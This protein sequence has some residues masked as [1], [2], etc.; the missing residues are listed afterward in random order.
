MSHAR[1]LAMPGETRMKDARLKAAS[2]AFAQALAFVA[3][4]VIAGIVL[5][6]R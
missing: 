2:G 3:M 5:Y 4:L 6:A 1:R